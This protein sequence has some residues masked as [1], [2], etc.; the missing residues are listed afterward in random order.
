MSLILGILLLILISAALTLWFF[1]KP[2]TSGGA[3]LSFL[4]RN[5]AYRGLWNERNPKGSLEAMMLAA[6]LNYGV[7][8][9]VRSTRERLLMVVGQRQLPLSTVLATL[10]GSAPLMIE[11]GGKKTSLRLCLLLAKVLDTYAGPF[12]VISRDPKI[13]AWFKNYRPSFARGQIVSSHSDFATSHLLRNYLTRP[14]FLVVEKDLRR[15]LSVLLLTKLVR[16][17]CFVF[18]VD[19]VEDY[20]ACR[21]A[22]CFAIFEKIRPR[23]RIKKGTHHEQFYL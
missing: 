1:L 22:H 6:R 11:I 3:D 17:P 16:L 7:K 20:R 4:R 8:I 15:R 19:T 12:A 5:Y 23:D 14:D 18:T 13:L 9:E 10:E 2:R 21:Q